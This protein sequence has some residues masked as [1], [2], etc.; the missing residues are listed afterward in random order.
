MIYSL[1]YQE[2]A[3]ICVLFCRF[4]FMGKRF[5][6]AY[7]VAL[8]FNCLILFPLNGVY[9]QEL[10]KPLRGVTLLSGNFG[11]LRATHFHAGLDIKTG[12]VEGLPVICVRDGIVSRVAVSPVGYGLALYIDHPDGTTS[13]YGHLQRFE[14]RVAALVRKIQYEKE[15]FRIDENLLKHRIYYKRGDTIAYSGNTGSSGGPH[16]HFEIRNT[17]TEHTWNPLLFY[18]IRDLKA[19]QLKALGL[20]SVKEDGRVEYIRTCPV[21]N[22]GGGNYT[23]GR[24][25]VPAGKVGI[26]V[27]ALDYMENSWNKLGVYTLD[28]V[29]GG[30]TLYHL[31]MD[32]CSFFQSRL[33]NGVKD[34][35]RY[36]KK[37]TVYRCF[38]QRQR[39][40]L[41]VRMKKDGTVFVEQDSV[42]KVSVCLSDI[43]GN[44][45]RLAFGLKGGVRDTADLPEGEVLR[46]G[47]PYLLEKGAWQVTLD[48]DALFSS[49]ERV[50]DVE[51]DSVSGREVLMLSRQD[52]PLYKK[53][54]LLVK[55]D[56]SDK[57]LLCEVTPAGRKYPLPTTRTVG[58]LEAEIDFLNRY[59]VVEDTVAP[60][61]VYL[62]KSAGQMLRFRIKDDFSGIASYRGE[63]NG[64]WCLFAYDPRVGIL[65][66]KRTEPMFVKGKANEVKIMVEDG[67][68]NRKELSVKVVV[69]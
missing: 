7:F 55:G 54:K 48:A 58:G 5:A 47:I 25:T 14:S 66:C 52:I 59:T 16:L 51:V 20:Y 8:V 53:A 36:K 15:S 50:L 19:P 10:L 4:I 44:T 39:A 43:N 63:V 6:K 27:Y 33:I 49:V 46:Y 65:Q 37:E 1:N 57:S 18:S 62:G 69:P 64:K 17:S 31:S 38:G 30:D 22:A 56:F 26:G 11:E 28:L 2:S 21:K 61:A 67:A 60:S 29:V 68:K 34:F 23:A 42:V 40:L 9:A 45:S 35:D 32:S 3:Y 12:G 13:V 41:G 24:Y